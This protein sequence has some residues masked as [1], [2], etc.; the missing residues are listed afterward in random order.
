MKDALGQSTLLLP[1][2]FLS[3]F[4]ILDASL[5]VDDRRTEF[6]NLRSHRSL[7]RKPCLR[8]LPME[9]EHVS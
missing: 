3:D 7:G 5:F 6:N 1:G 2:T 8:S 4:G 9:A